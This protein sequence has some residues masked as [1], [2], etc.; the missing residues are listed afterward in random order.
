MPLIMRVCV[1]FID[2]YFQKSGRTQVPEE[3]CQLCEEGE[4]IRQ[5]SSYGFDAKVQE[6]LESQSET[7]SE[8]EPKAEESF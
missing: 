4:D 6:S 8:G 5:E 2:L 1:F 7:K 3:A